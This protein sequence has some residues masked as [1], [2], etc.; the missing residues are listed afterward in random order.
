MRLSL[1]RLEQCSGMPEIE[2]IKAREAGLAAVGG[3]VLSVH[4]VQVLC[5]ADLCGVGAPAEQDWFAAHSTA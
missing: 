5:R 2:K 3:A 1:D 4:Q